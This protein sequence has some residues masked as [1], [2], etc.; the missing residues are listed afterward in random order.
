MQGLSVPVSVCACVLVQDI[1]VPVGTKDDLTSG[2]IGGGGRFPTRGEPPLIQIGWIFTSFCLTLQ[3]GSQV[4]G[5]EV[6]VLS[7]DGFPEHSSQ[8][9]V[10]TPPFPLYCPSDSQPTGRTEW[11]G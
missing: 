1:K 4:C 9:A 10:R 11:S 6:K 3:F 8:P 5:F 2:D 7:K